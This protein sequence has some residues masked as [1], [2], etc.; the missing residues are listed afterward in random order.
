MNAAS[1]PTYNNSDFETVLKRLNPAR[2]SK[3]ALKSCES[4]LAEPK[5]VNNMILPM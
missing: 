1:I 3:C 5:A 2:N 4:T